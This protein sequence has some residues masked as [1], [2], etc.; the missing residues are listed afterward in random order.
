MHIRNRDLVFLGC[1]YG[2]GCVRRYVAWEG[3]FF[4][5]EP[6]CIERPSVVEAVRSMSL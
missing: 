5:A 4:R 6:L 3:R 1:P 2:I